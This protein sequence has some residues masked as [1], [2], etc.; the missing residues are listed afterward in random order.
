MLPLNAWWS[1]VTGEHYLSFSLTDCFHTSPQIRQRMRKYT[2]MLTLKVSL[3][4]C[5]GTITW[6]WKNIKD[7]S[8]HPF[9][10]RDYISLNFLLSWFCPLVC[11]IL[12]PAFQSW[13]AEAG[14]KR[15]TRRSRRSLRKRR[16]TSGKSLK[17][18]S[19]ILSIIIN[20][21]LIINT[22]KVKLNSLKW[23][24]LSRYLD[25]TFSQE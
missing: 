10:D 9:Y 22:N 8:V 14:L 17:S 21:V 2:T 13:K 23:L 5:P 16:R 15:W 20:P 24:L 3:H 18:V 4:L 1:Q 25:G 7:N 6:I 11:F 12:S 19:L